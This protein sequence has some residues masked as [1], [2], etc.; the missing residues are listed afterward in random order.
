MT[1]SPRDFLFVQSATEMGGAEVVLFNLFE[2]SPELR[3][4]S[5]VANLSFG[6]GEF[7]GRLRAAG[8][9]VV[10]LPKARV[11]DL[12]GVGRTVAALRGLIRS[13]GIRVVIGNG[14]H[15]QILGALAARFA[16][17]RSVFLVHMIY[18]WPWWKHPLLEVLA[19]KGPVD[20][21]LCVSKAARDA[22]QEIRPRVDCRLLY[23][24]TPERDVSAADTRAAREE[25]GVGPDDVVFG[26]FGRLQRWKGQD[27]FV[28]AAIEVGRARPASRFVV[29]GGSVFGLEPEFLASLQQR[30]RVQGMDGRI[31]F[32]GFRSDV[33]RLMAACDVVCHT[34]RVPEP[35]GLVVIEAMMLGRPV[36]ATRG[37]G[38]SE[39]IASEE[40]GVLVT[41]DDPA[42]LAAEM[43]RL[44]DD[45]A[46]R[47]RLGA[48]SG[49]HVR[50]NFGIERMARELLAHLESLL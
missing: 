41:P 17:V 19:V 38:P 42:A 31:T 22:I 20:L 18:A 23:D 43:I 37:G 30:V 21:M 46:R 7:P 40:L 26:V 14:D 50:A 2:C 4:R 6:S 34:S 15:P 16:G 12:V 5:V 8:V 47:E 35:F 36:I 13:R 28:S 27:V 33:P 10:D 39:V 25:L 24:G 48:A 45:R 32:T 1:D 44:C 49:I 3:R 11:R 29:V 9:E